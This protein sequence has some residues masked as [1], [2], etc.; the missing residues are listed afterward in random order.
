LRLQ[1]F[2]FDLILTSKSNEIVSD[3]HN[4]AH[5]G[6]LNKT[7]MVEQFF[8]DVVEAGYV[9]DLRLKLSAKKTNSAA[10]SKTIP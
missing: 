7:Q 10:N 8:R 9:T 1:Y 2:V 4:S 6:N 5:F 3:I